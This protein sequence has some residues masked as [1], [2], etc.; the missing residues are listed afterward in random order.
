MGKCVDFIEVILQLRSY[1]SAK[2]CS[3]AVGRIWSAWVLHGRHYYLVLL[4]PQLFWGSTH[5]DFQGGGFEVQ[6]TPHPLLSWLFDLVGP[7]HLGRGAGGL[8]PR[9]WLRKQ[10]LCQWFSQGWPGVLLPLYF[11][12]TTLAFFIVI[13]RRHRAVE[14]KTTAVKF[15]NDASQALLN[16]F[17]A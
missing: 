3:R 13:G 10:A 2:S 4:F 12:T 1:P 15:R 8:C 9:I 17:W 11:L 7:S 6:K 14:R 16:L 5:V